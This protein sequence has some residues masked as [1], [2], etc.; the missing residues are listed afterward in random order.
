MQKRRAA[1]PGR[2]RRVFPCD[3]DPAVSRL[4]PVRADAA[5][6][7]RCVRR[8]SRLAAEQPR[9]APECRSASEDVQWADSVP[10]DAVGRGPETAVEAQQPSVRRV[11]DIERGR[12]KLGI[13]GAHLLPVPAGVAADGQVVVARQPQPVRR[14]GRERD[15]L[16]ALELTGPRRTGQGHAGHRAPS[17]SA[18]GR[19]QHDLFA[20]AV[21][22]HRPGVAQ[23]PGGDARGADKRT[24]VARLPTPADRSRV[25]PA[26]HVASM[27]HLETAGAAAVSDHARDQASG[28]HGQL[29]RLRVRCGSPRQPDPA[30]ARA[31]RARSPQLRVT[32]E[33]LTRHPDAGQ[34]P[35][36][37]TG[38]LDL[39]DR[40]R[41][42]LHR[43]R[44]QAGKLTPGDSRAARAHRCPAVPAAARGDRA[45]VNA[46]G[47]DPHPASARNASETSASRSATL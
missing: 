38:D 36:R 18:V 22:S 15:G 46:A 4:L 10:A 26:A 45:V 11:E 44:C 3:R 13:N 31:R 32:R 25:S 33:L 6:P 5:P 37:C 42:A 47:A 19:A 21:A 2:L 23:Q 14:S 35:D 17:A 16:R 41:Q 30:P 27:R 1:G 34:R 20:V 40:S 8:T 9:S 29:Y 12:G 43:P 39:A 24:A 28:E 7:A